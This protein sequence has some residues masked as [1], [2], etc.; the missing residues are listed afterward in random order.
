MD[1]EKP[2]LPAYLNE[3]FLTEIVTWLEKAAAEIIVKVIHLDIHFYFIVIVLN[4]FHVPVE[5][6][7]N[8]LVQ[9]VPMKIPKQNPAI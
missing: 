2:V 7:Q 9:L 5:R 3:S 4:H 6:R 8:N 1:S